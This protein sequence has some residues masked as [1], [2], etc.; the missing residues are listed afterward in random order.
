MV[1]FIGNKRI[2]LIN[3]RIAGVI[4]HKKTGIGFLLLKCNNL[5]KIISG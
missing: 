3:D 4:C 2:T 5:I 1:F